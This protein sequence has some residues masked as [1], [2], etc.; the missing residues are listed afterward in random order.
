[1]R[2][3]R[4]ALGSSLVP[5]TICPEIHRGFLKLLQVRA[6]FPTSFPIRDS[7]IIMLFYFIQGVSM[8]SVP[9]RIF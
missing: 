7:L 2:L 1:M 8:Q 6:V 3:I 5:K 4:K 9:G